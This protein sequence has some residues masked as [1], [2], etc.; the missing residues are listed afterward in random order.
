[1]NPKEL[2]ERVVDR[3]NAHDWDGLAALWSDEAEIYVPGGERLTGARQWADFN[4]QAM[5]A[6]PN[7]RVDVRRLIIDGN[8]VVQE[9][10]VVATHTEVLTLPDGRQLQPTGASVE[11]P[12]MEVFWI[13][14]DKIAGVHLYVDPTEIERQLV[15]P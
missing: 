6:F 14:N 1:M 11:I 15:T 3:F 10:V 7:A 12:Y 4:R 8:T 13:E 5:A 2:F 9:S